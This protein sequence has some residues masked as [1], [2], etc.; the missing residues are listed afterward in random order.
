MCALSGGGDSIPTLLHARTSRFKTL[1]MVF[2]TSTLYARLR[3]SCDM[4][5]GAATGG[6]GH[7]L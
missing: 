4:I 1:P 5:R 6:T 7:E 3:D 2:E